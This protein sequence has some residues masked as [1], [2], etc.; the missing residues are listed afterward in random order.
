MGSAMLP[1]PPAAR[2]YRVSH[3]MN[4]YIK[5]MGRNGAV[6]FLKVFPWFYY[7]AAEGTPM[8]HPRPV[9]VRARCA[10]N[11]RWSL[12]YSAFELAGG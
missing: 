6:F 4:W 8:F 9:S 11:K 2:L 10:I 12:F 7:S 3:V 5:I 1:T